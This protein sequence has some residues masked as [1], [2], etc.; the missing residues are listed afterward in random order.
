MWRML[1]GAGLR[2]WGVG[3]AEPAPEEGLEEVGLGHREYR[4]HS[5]PGYSGH[6]HGVEGKSTLTLEL[7]IDPQSTQ[8]SKNKWRH[9]SNTCHK[10]ERVEE[11]GH[12]D[13]CRRDT[14]K[15]GS[16]ALIQAEEEELLWVMGVR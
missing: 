16:R 3:E 15:V 5:S 1:G 12:G 11:V 9:E 2:R 13:N 6:H 4:R 7:H 10:V 8:G 14:D